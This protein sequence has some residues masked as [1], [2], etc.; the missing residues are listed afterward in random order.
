MKTH[1]IAFIKKLILTILLI[2]LCFNLFSQTQGQLNEE[3]FVRYKKVDNELSV[4]YQ[5]IIS[6]Y[7]NKTEFINALRA[8]ERI[9]IQFRDA[10]VKMKFPAANPKFE[11]GSMYSMCINDLLRELTLTRLNEL[12]IWLQPISE[13]ETCNGSIGD[14]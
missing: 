1:P 8:S 5:K 13:G 9:W 11:Y 7:A 10:E 14:F 2:F 4:V 12:K 6:K 3:A